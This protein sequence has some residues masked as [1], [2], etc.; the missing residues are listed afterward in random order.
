MAPEGPVLP[1]EARLVFRDLEDVPAATFDDDRLECALSSSLGVR[2]LGATWVRHRFVPR[3]MSLVCL[4]VGVRAA[5]HTWPER[6][7]LSLDLYGTDPEL[8]TVF[9]RCL[10]AILA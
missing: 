7:A 3:G 5:L 8:E 10:D 2:A 6:S 9:A 4:G 1:V